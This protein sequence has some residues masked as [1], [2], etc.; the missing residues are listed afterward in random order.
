MGDKNDKNKHKKKM[1]TKE[2]KAMNHLRL[3]EGS[4]E[5]HA[6]TTIVASDQN[7]DKKAA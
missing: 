2:K 5:R 4:K 6:A 7:K 3:M 1:T